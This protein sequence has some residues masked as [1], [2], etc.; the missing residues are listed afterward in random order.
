[1]EK[2]TLKN[3]AKKNNSIELP[4]LNSK[5]LYWIK[6]TDKCPDPKLIGEKHLCTGEMVLIFISKEYGILC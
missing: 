1:M 6:F 2:N 5:E 4:E 3:K